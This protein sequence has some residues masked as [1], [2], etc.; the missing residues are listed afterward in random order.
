MILIE[1]VWCWD[2]VTK[3]VD[4]VI[5]FIRSYKDGAFTQW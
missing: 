4:V 2:L 5:F 3:E 1:S